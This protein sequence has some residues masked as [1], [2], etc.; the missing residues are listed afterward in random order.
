MLTL[1]LLLIL[2]VAILVVGC[3]GNSDVSDVPV[4]P[5][6]ANSRVSITND[7]ETLGARVAYPDE[8]VIIEDLTGAPAALSLPP[9]LNLP[10]AAKASST[11]ASLTLVSEILPPVVEGETVQ[12]TAV[13]LSIQGEATVSYN[14]RG[15]P[16]LGAIDYVSRFNVSRPELTSGIAFTDSDINA[17]A[18]DGVFVYTANRE[19]LS[20]FAATSVLPTQQ[21][22]YATSGNEGDVFAFDSSDHSLLGQFPLHDARWV[23]RDRDNSRIVVVQGTPGMISVFEEG[24]FP[25]GSMNLLNS[26]PFD[27][28]NVAESKSTVEVAG[29]KAFIAAGPDGVKV[30]CLDNGAIIGSVPRPDPASLG[31]DPSVVVTNAVSVDGD[32]MFISNGEA[33]VYLAE[34]AA[35]FNDN[36]CDPQEITVLGK[37]RFDDL[38]SAN[39]VDYKSGYL[40]VAAGLGGVKVVRVSFK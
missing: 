10:S 40:Y 35:S 25:G 22:V 32:L 15:A 5:D 9:S 30:M 19:P 3:N 36:N 26:F 6:E 23:A 28:A 38:Q 37:L 29:G 18:T 16:R 34:A 13:N 20:S 2:A 8:N 7:L 24:V 4:L 17:V 1:R 27:G 12:A 14:M 31:L 33:G 21:V 39:H 11:V